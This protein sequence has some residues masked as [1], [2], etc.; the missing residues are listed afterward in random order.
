MV[1]LF[2]IEVEYISAA[3]CCVQI[4][5]MKQTLLDFGM[6]Y[7]HVSIRRDNTRAINLSKNPILHSCAKHINISHHFLC[8]HM[9]NGDIMLKLM[10]TEKQLADIFTKPLYD[11]HFS[12]IRRKLVKLCYSMNC[13]H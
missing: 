11:D 12:A 8:D 3:C 10:S 2:T 7:K 13:M 9:Q 1:A 6:S 5:W 4:L